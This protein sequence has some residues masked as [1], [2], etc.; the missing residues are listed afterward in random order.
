M[1][2]CLKRIDMDKLGLLLRNSIK[3]S[4]LNHGLSKSITQTLSYGI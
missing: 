4:K 2:H 1:L 3:I